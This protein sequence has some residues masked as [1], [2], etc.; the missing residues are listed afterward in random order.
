MNRRHFMAGSLALAG[1]QKF[2]HSHWA[3][4]HPLTD[5][6]RAAQQSA[7]PQEKPALVAPHDLLSTTYSAAFLEGHLMAPGAWHPY[8]KWSERAA[9]EAVPA[10]IRAAVVTRAEADQKAGWKALLA[11]TFLD[12]KRNGNRSRFEDS[13]FAR[14]AMLQHL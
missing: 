13:S 2:L 4:L 12:F 7:S 14:R 6:A 1:Q 9:W 5:L 11:S 3:L 8:P 10:D